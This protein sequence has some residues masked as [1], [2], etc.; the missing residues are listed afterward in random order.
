MKANEYIIVI[1]RQFGAGGREVGHALAGRLS[2]PY[3]DK[4]LLREA[5]RQ[6][7]IRE[8]V[9]RNADESRP[10]FLGS[11]FGLGASGTVESYT[12]SAMSRS[13][14]YKAQSEVVEE[15]ASRGPCVLVGR[16][17]D[18]VLRERPNLVSLFLHAPLDKR[19]VRIVGRGNC[20][21]EQDARQMAQKRDRLRE[22]YYNF[23]TGRH[24]GHA[25]NYH[26]SID[27]SSMTTPQ[28]VDFIVSYLENKK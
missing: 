20:A 26:L 25:D 9:F 5:A 13:G 7:G 2:L 15:I 21:T 14:L 19:A 4:E 16:T 18:Y 28:I 23:F 10:S 22:S 27:A 11:L 24:W 8:E 17:A 6:S 12:T 1:G 3:Y